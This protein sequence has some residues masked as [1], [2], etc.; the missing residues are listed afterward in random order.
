MHSNK[1]ETPPR[2]NHNWIQLFTGSQFYPLDP[3]PEDFTLEDLAHGLALENRFNGASL[4]PISVAEHSVRVSLCVEGLAMASNWPMNKVITAA[5]AGWGH[6]AH[7]ALG[8]RDIARPLKH[9]PEF[10]PYREGCERCQEVVWEKFGIPI[11]HEIAEIVHYADNVQLA[12]EKR[13]LMAPPPS[14]WTGLPPPM[15]EYLE[16]W[17]WE[18]AE[19]MF[20]SR[21]Q[22]LSNLLKNPGV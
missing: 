9:T 12:T 17:P 15:P 21:Y 13:D 5:L 16:P 1:S 3:K 14:P 6:D 11:D 7:E 20:L 2:T 18:Q 19:C 4:L 22:H 10:E 8:W